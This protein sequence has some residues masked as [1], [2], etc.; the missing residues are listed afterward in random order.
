MPS[1]QGA[2][3]VDVPAAHP[4]QLCCPAARGG[5]PEFVLVQAPVAVISEEDDGAVWLGQ[6]TADLFG[7]TTPVPQASGV[8]GLHLQA[9]SGQHIVAGALEEDE[10]A[11]RRKEEGC[12]GVTGQ[13]PCTARL[14]GPPHWLGA[15]EPP[16]STPC[17]ALRELG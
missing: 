9:P 15:P 1:E 4:G 11:Q 16:A 12:V 14:W 2:P 7:D 8:V 13:A 6:G 10:A 17:E 5:H 3:R